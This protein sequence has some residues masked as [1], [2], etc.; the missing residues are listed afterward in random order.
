MQ[1]FV[2]LNISEGLYY[3]ESAYT[4]KSECK[5]SDATI[6]IKS[7]LL[8]IT[9]AKFLLTSTFHCQILTDVLIAYHIV[10]QCVLSSLCH[11]WQLPAK[12]KNHVSRW[13]PP[14]EKAFAVAKCLNLAITE[15]SYIYCSLCIAVLAGKIPAEKTH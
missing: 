3:A 4:I 10:I 5:K 8:N 9:T 2:E 15:K 12:R 14:L 6:E 1:L 13:H 7:W 11:Y